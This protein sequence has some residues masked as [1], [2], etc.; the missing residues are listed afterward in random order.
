MS[1]TSFYDS[2]FIFNFVD[3]YVE[4]M[5]FHKKESESGIHSLLA[6]VT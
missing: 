2:F 3:R 1:Q 4:Q 5:I 6:W